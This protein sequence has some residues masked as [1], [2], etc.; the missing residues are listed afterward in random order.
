MPKT[1]QI[2]LPG[3]RSLVLAAVLLA[4]AAMGAG[5][6][7][8]VAHRQATCQ[9]SRPA[10]GE[11]AKPG[12]WGELSR[13]SFTIAAPEEALPVRALAARRTHWLF[14]SAM[15]SEVRALLANAEVPPGM[16]DSLLL[17][18]N[19]TAGADGLD[20]APPLAWL[21]ELPADVRKQLYHQL[22]QIPTIAG[23]FTYVHKETLDERFADSG[24][25]SETLELFHDLCAEQGDYLVF[26][27]LETM[28]AEL[29]V[30]DQKVRFLKALT[31]QKTMLLQ[32]YVGP[33]SDLDALANYWGKGSNTTDV[34]TKLQSLAKVKGGAWIGITL[35]LP[36]LP[37]AEIYTYP[38]IGENPAAGSGAATRDCHWT[39]L[40]FFRQTPD[41]SFSNAQSV[42]EEFRKAYCAATGDP[43]Y[44]DVVLLS[45]PD[46]TP[47]HSA[48]YVA[49]DIVFTKNGATVVSPWMLSTLPDMLK[50]Y[51]FQV[52]PDQ[53]LTVTYL[54]KVTL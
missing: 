35:L 54:R 34:R 16:R 24:V 8:F 48:V 21:A 2:R 44:G 18:E 20:V 50:R 6:S 30:Y 46:G 19:V 33:E 25:D 53:R 52:S 5:I 31:R 29:P 51:S 17:P 4:G 49:D 9:R 11:L 23:G 45:K 40:N 13:A 38:L 3:R 22:A 15:E 14:P 27:G 41:Q 47:V 7:Q 10:V 36:P 28:L 37:R 32:L 1:F 12:P 26:T 42:Q 39:S 43:Q